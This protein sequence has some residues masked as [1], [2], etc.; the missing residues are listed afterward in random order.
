MT[1]NAGEGAIKTANQMY[2]FNTTI[3]LNSSNV[4]YINGQTQQS[5]SIINIAT[6]DNGTISSSTA[7]L[8]LGADN[9]FG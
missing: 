1:I 4:F 2:W 6:Y 5:E 8:I 9:D 3:T 7:D